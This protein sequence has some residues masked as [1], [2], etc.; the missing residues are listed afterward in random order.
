MEHQFYL[1]EYLPEYGYSIWQVFSPKWMKW[2]CHFKAVK[3]IVFVANDK[4]CILKQKLEF[5]KTCIPHCELHIF[6]LPKDFSD[7]I[8]GDIN[9]YMLFHCRRKPQHLEDLQNLVNP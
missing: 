3:L 4:I 5:W 2:T 6:S 7:E 9:K 1:K 8:H